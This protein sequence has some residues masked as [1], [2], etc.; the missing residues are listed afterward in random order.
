M[1]NGVL[2][3]E[4]FIGPPLPPVISLMEKTKKRSAEVPQRVLPTYNTGRK[5]GVPVLSRP[6]QKL[7]TKRIQ[8]QLIDFIWS[9]ARYLNRDVQTVSCWTDFNMLR[10]R[11]K[12]VRKD[13]VGY[14]PKIEAPATI[15]TML[16]QLR[17]VLT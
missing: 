2:V 5:P 17:T 16:T 8:V 12:Q 1:L 9:L 14:L 7:S 6:D 3:Q 15:K 13:T 10:R 4:A 11:N